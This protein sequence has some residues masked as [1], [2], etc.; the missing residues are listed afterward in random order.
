MSSAAVTG[1][2][3]GLLHRS[4]GGSDAGDLQKKVRSRFF[5]CGTL[6]FQDFAGKCGENGE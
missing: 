2:A 5:I 1:D 3:A 4:P 6:K